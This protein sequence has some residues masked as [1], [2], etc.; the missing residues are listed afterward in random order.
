MSCDRERPAQQPSRSQY[1]IGSIR[2][3]CRRFDPAPYRRGPAVSRRNRSH[4]TSELPKSLTAAGNRAAMPLPLFSMMALEKRLRQV[5]NVRTCS[6]ADGHGLDPLQPGMVIH[7]LLSTG[8][9]SAHLMVLTVRYSG[10]E[11]LHLAEPYEHRAT[12]DLDGPRQVRDIRACKRLGRLQLA[13]HGERWHWSSQRSV[14]AITNLAGV[15]TATTIPAGGKNLPPEYDA[16]EV[17]I[18][19]PPQTKEQPVVPIA[20]AGLVE[21][22]LTPPRPPARQ[23]TRPHL[24]CNRHNSALARVLMSVIHGQQS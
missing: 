23:A 22:N 16:A 20:R 5:R 10:G 3:S 8:G 18:G 4:A 14:T 21:S 11:I 13:V 19:D 6:R 9:Q 15:G 17:G 2:L 7:Y 12:S 24:R 1:A